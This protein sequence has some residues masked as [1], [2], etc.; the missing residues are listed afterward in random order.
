I[1]EFV[2]INPVK[3]VPALVDGDTVVSDS[4]AIILYLEDKYPQY[5]LLPQ[6]LKKKALNLQV[7]SIVSSSIQPLQSIT[8]LSWIESKFNTDER[9]KWAQHHINK[10]FIALEKLLKDRAGN[11]ATG[12]EVQLADVFLEPQ[13]YAGVKRPKSL[14][15]IRLIK[16]TNGLD[17]H[18][19]WITCSR[20]GQSSLP[21]GKGFVVL[22][23]CYIFNPLRQSFVLIGGNEKKFIQTFSAYYPKIFVAIACGFVGRKET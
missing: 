13:I 10:G 9:L 16:W 4:F 14:R 23:E 12:D 19:L 5:P 22:L 20:H 2:K 3:Y 21:F 8:V 17:H 11:Y 6:D 18:R 1:L 15:S 7:A